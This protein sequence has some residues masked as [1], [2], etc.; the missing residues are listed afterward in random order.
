MKA[1]RVGEAL[2]GEPR[3]FSEGSKAGAQAK[4]P[5]VNGFE[6]GR[7]FNGAMIHRPSVVHEPHKLKPIAADPRRF[8]VF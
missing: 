2:L 7:H 4:R 5:E 1:G 8:A 6:V 3:P